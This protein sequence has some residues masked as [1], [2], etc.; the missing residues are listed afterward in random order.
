MA[1]ATRLPTLE[2]VS[3]R[4]AEAVQ[5]LDRARDRATRVERMLEE[6]KKAWK[7]ALAHAAE[8]P[9]LAAVLDGEDS[10]PLGTG[11][12]EQAFRRLQ[13]L[14]KQARAELSTAEAAVRK[15][16]QRDAGLLVQALADERMPLLRAM[17]AG[18]DETLAA[19]KRLR[20]LDEYLTRQLASPSGGGLRLHSIEPM[21]RAVR[22]LRDELAAAVDSGR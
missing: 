6:A 15:A 18:L 5:E 3:P 16:Q 19:E 13:P 22:A 14:A 1:T 12:A 4:C 17:L 21:L 10:S 20:P 2:E 9:D 11:E 8:P 7:R